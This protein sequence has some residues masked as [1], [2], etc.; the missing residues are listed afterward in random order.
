[1]DLK[2]P[3]GKHPAGKNPKLGNFEKYFGSGSVAKKSSGRVG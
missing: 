2:R 1:M 3:A